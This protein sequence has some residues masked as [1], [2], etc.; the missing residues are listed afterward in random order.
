MKYIAVAVMGVVLCGCNSYDVR[1]LKYDPDMRS[2][3]VI[4]NS[5]VR[6]DDFENVLGDNFAAHGIAV[7]H[8]DSN[9]MPVPGEYVVTYNALRSWD[10][11]AYLSDADVSVRKDAY[12]VGRGHY[13][14]IGGS[15]SLDV[16]TKWRGTAWKMQDLYDELLREY[17]GK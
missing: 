5:A 13:E 8:V 17:K 14:H 3:T 2:V 12:E 11:V 6:V 4:R 1:A 10:C 9:Y 16:F 7:K 15:M